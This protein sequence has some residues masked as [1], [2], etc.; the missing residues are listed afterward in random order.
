MP[1]KTASYRVIDF[2][3]REIVRFRSE[4]TGVA[5]ISRVE[6]KIIPDGNPNVQLEFRQD[7][8]WW[9]QSR[10]VGG[11]RVRIPV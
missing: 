4:S 7:G 1:P 11:E 2:N 9:A 6:T 8:F 10:W 5:A 3:G